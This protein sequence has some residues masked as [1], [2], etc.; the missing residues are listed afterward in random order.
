MRFCDL[1]PVIFERLLEPIFRG[2]RTVKAGQDGSERHADSSRL[3]ITG[4]LV[5]FQRGAFLSINDL[6]GINHSF[7]KISSATISD[8]DKLSKRVFRALNELNVDL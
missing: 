3:L 1:M 7:L 5:R 6:E 8:W 4:L 2:A